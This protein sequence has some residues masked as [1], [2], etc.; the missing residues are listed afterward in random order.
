M[1]GF[2]FLLIQWGCSPVVDDEIAL[3]TPI[4]FSESYTATPTITLTPTPTP[5]IAPT[6]T[7]N[8]L[9]T[10]TPTPEP[11]RD[12]YME[13]LMA[14]KYGGGVLEDMGNLNGALGFTR[15]LFRYRSDGL[16]LYGFIN[17]PAGEG[18]F[19]V[20]VMAHGYID[21]AE[22][23]TLDY[24]VRYADA[25]TEAGYIAIHP[26]LRGYGPSQNGENVL[27]IGDTIDVLNLIAL[28]RQ[29]A[30]SEGLLKTADGERIGLWGHSMGGAIV[31]RTLI[32]DT[33]VKAGLL[34]ASINM[35]EAI[36]LSHF[37]KDGRGNE[38]VEA[39]RAVLSLLSPKDYLDAVEVPVAIFHGGKDEVV[40]ATWSRNLCT[41]LS[42]MNKNVTCWEYPDQLHTF[43]NSGDTQFIGEMIAFFETT[44][45]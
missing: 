36:N 22:F 13:T 26:N 20:I 43:Q 23:S 42:D 32:A 11:Y 1:V 10:L 27:G 17:I 25:L 45:R 37:D 6:A 2:V 33:Q 31:M 21:P 16:D 28:V 3:P 12:L 24:S 35:D 18:P 29:Q 39:S 30:G 7:V 40:P 9:I 15:K 8:R 4:S 34:Y 14:R 41:M 5:T 19:P 44:V 38:K